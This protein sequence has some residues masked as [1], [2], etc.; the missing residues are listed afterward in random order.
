MFYFFRLILLLF[1]FQIGIGFLL[2]LLPYGPLM[3]FSPI[4]FTIL[5]CSYIVYKRDL[6]AL[7][8]LFSNPVSE[9]RRKQILEWWIKIHAK[10][11]P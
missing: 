5:C 1:L 8:A 7:N 2:Y 11:S 9:E 10:Q 4:V 3:F 6:N